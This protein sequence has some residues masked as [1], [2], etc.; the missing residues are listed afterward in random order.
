M[1]HAGALRTATDDIVAAALLGDGWED[2]LTRFADAADAGGASLM[3]N[4]GP[5]LAA[6]LYTP[7]IEEP[8]RQFLAGRTP[9]LSRQVRARTGLQ[10]RF[11]V[12]HDDFTAE[13][14]RV[15]AYYQEFLRTHGFFWHANATLA[16]EGPE[17]IDLSLKRR[18]A[19]GPYAPADVAKLDA[20]LRDLRLMVRLTTGLFDARAGGVVELLRQR[21]EPVFELDAWG[22]VRRTHGGEPDGDCPVRV[23]GRRLTVADGA[24]QR[25]LDRAVM[26]AARGSERIGAV[27]LP[28]DGAQRYAVQIIHLAGRAR[29]IFM[30]SAAVA[31]LLTSPTRPAHQRL[32]R[33]L[34]RDAFQLTDRETDVAVLVGEGMSVERIAQTLGLQVATLRGYLK[35]V[36]EKTG[37]SRQAELAALLGRLRP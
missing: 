36:F 20:V 37:T 26:A 1:I 21:G 32:E 5:R 22:R 34:V 25:A 24:A 10:Y 28:P 14:L 11:R 31:V 33:V 4:H 27:N 16:G 9:P 15:D 8:V 6:T 7:S 18:L 2:A 17:T 29:D 3:C 30:A 19:A 23:I 13:A 12:D 35:S